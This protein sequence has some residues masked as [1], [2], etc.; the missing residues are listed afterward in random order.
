MGDDSE[1][2]ENKTA[3]NDKKKEENA[4][5]AGLNE[6]SE[7]LGKVNMGKMGGGQQNVKKQRKKSFHV[8]NTQF[9]IS[10]VDYRLIRLIGYGAYGVV[11]SAEDCKTNRKVRY[12]IRGCLS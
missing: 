7:S 2:N 4:S 10:P 11:V 12:C 6:S 9:D 8:M 5:G 3:V 1:K